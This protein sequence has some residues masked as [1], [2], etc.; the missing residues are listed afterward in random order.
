[1][2]LLQVS[3]EAQSCNCETEKAVPLAVL[4]LRNRNAKNPPAQV[5]QD[6]L[7]WRTREE[8]T[9]THAHTHTLIITFTI[10]GKM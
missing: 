9:H 6:A 5:T 2:L 3:M 8:L 7:G 4:L 1:M 10:R